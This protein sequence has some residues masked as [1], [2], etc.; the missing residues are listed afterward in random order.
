MIFN[1]ISIVA[2]ATEP[3]YT[4]IAG[5]K[6]PC[7]GCSGRMHNNIT[8]YNQNPGRLWSSTIEQQSDRAAKNTVTLLLSKS[9]HITQSKDRKQLRDYDS[10]SDSELD[11]PRQP[12]LEFKSKGI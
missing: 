6:R 10:G 12:K 2:K 11:T 3:I 9:S 8:Q 1:K 5:K 7:M 4:C